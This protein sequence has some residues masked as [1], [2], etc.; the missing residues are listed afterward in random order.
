MTKL[1][2]IRDLWIEGRSGDDWHKIVKG[3]SLDLMAAL[4]ARRQHEGGRRLRGQL[5]RLDQPAKIDRPRDPAGQGR[6]H[7]RQPC[8]DRPDHQM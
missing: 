4:N 1:L 7:I 2:E 8:G 5:A 3:V 6:D